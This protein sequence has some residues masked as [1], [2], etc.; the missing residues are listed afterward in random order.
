MF[1]FTVT[2]RI[3]GQQLREAGYADRLFVDEHG[4]S[5]VRFESGTDHFKN[6]SLLTLCFLLND[7]GIPFA[8][9]FKQL[10]SPAGFM[11]ELQRQLVLRKAYRSIS[12]KSASAPDW[13]CIV[14]E[15]A[16]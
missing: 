3:F 5:A 13:S 1:G 12:A 11:G 16:A 4:Y 7:L 6:I 14:H 2:H 15:P 8:A 10:W 9:D